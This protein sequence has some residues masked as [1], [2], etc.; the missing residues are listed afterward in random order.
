MA[1]IVTLQQL[2]I[3]VPR[4]VGY[5]LQGH[6]PASL[7]SFVLMEE[8]APVISLEDIARDW[9]EIPP[10]FLFKQK[11][12][13]EVARITRVM[14][15][16]GMNHRDLYICHF[17]LDTA[18]VSAMKLYLI[19]LHRAQIRSKTPLRWIIKDLA[20]LYFSSQEI[21]LTE[22]DKFRFMKKYTGKSLRDIMKTE[23]TFWINVDKR[24]STYRDHTK[25]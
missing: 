15:Q 20:A 13:E 23:K 24:G 25:K 14:H 10:A 1:S 4:V 21:G 19:D 5:G 3:A 17:L 7:Q 2:G 9:R 16:Q 18:H 12:I 6:N 22:R 8:V 11:L